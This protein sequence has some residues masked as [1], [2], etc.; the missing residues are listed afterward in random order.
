MN[1]ARVHFDIMKHIIH[2]DRPT[3]YMQHRQNPTVY[4]MQIIEIE[5]T[6]QK[7]PI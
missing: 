6:H 4:T 7:N 2:I 5:Y 3:L 1:K